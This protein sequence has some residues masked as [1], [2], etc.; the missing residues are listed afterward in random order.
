MRILMRT[1]ENPLIHALVWAFMPAGIATLKRNATWLPARQGIHRKFKILFLVA[2]YA[3]TPRFS[4]TDE[5][6]CNRQEATPARAE[7]MSR[8]W[9]DSNGVWPISRS[10]QENV[11]LLRGSCERWRRQGGKT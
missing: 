11:H 6:K 10:F 2:V 4:D 3:G 7:S 1:A 5:R 9:P 8:L